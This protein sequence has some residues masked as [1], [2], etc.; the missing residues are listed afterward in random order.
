MIHGPTTWFCKQGFIESQS[1]LFIYI[2]LWLLSYTFQSWTVARNTLGPIKLKIK[3]SYNLITIF[4]I[5]SVT[6]CILLGTPRT[7]P[8]HS[9]SRGIEVFSVSLSVFLSLPVSHTPAHVHTQAESC[10]DLGNK[11]LIFHQLC[12]YLL[13]RTHEIVCYLRWHGE[14]ETFYY[15]AHRKYERLSL[16]AGVVASIHLLSTCSLNLLNTMWKSWLETQH[17]KN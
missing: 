13:P 16:A 9:A 17:S 5:V 15:R 4:S 7:Q 2:S 8:L 10:P 11:T 12:I 3:G 1:H 6:K 14:Y